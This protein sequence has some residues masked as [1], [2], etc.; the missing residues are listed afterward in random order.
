MTSNTCYCGIITP[1]IITKFT[2]FKISNFVTVT[3]SLDELYKHLKLTLGT[4]ILGNII[5]LF[6][7]PPK[8]V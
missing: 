8:E 2:S 4:I 7:N 1:E 3:A 5:I 6:Q